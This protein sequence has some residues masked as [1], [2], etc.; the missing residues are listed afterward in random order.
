MPMPKMDVKRDVARRANLRNRI[1]AFK[2]TRTH[3]SEG[4]FG[5]PPFSGHG[6]FIGSN[7]GGGRGTLG[8]EGWHFPMQDK[9]ANE[10]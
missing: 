4:R 8:V 6:Q 9:R 1:I 5:L 7:K 10:V 3:T 2:W